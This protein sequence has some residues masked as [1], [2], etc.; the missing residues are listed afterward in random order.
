MQR[1]RIM[2][3]ELQ[4]IELTI[5]DELKEGVFAISLV[6]KPAIEEDWVMLN[7]LQVDLKVVNEEKRELIGLAL[8]PNKKILRR[9]DNIDFNIEFSEQTVEK[10]QELYLKNLRANNVTIDHEKP[11]NGVSLIESWIV[12]DPKNDK[13]NIYNLNAVKGAWAVKLKVYN[14]DIWELAKVGKINGISI[15]GMFDGLDQ[16]KMSEQTEDE[17]L[18]EEIK[19]LLAKL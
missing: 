9:K 3:K 18:I 5:K 14:D 6:D 13:S 17:L 7:S 10:V 12:E 15:E 19:D 2:K 16:L 8:V 4:T 11:V 1:Y